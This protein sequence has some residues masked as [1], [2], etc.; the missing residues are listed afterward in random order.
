MCALDFETSNAMEHP[1]LRSRAL[2]LDQHIPVASPLPSHR[3]FHPVVR[4]RRLRRPSFL[5]DDNKPSASV[6]TLPLA[7]IPLSVFYSQK[8]PLRLVC[9]FPYLLL[10]PAPPSAPTPAPVAPHPDRHLLPAY[11]V[12]HIRTLSRRY[13]LRLLL[14][15]RRASDFTIR[16]PCGFPSLVSGPSATTPHTSNLSSL[17]PALPSTYLPTYAIRACRPASDRPNRLIGGWLPPRD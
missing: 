3:P 7:V 8:E 11:L 15:C 2:Y 12:L 6:G 16:P 17:R 13:L 14:P 4:D 9:V 10:A 1:I 5:V